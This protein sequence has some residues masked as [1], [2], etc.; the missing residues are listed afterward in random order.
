MNSIIAPHLRKHPLK[1][2]IKVPVRHYFVEKEKRACSLV[3]IMNSHIWF[4]GETILYC[5]LFLAQTI[6]HPKLLS[7]L[8]GFIPGWAFEVVV[9]RT[10]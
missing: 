7:V 9:R 1:K 4:K 6:K 2:I 8:F 10:S 5:K 3:G